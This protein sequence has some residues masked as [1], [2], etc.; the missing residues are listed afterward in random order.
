M[1]E[2]RTHKVKFFSITPLI[3]KIGS[4]TA[5][6]TGGVWAGGGLWGAKMRRYICTREDTWCGEI[7][8]KQEE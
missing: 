7:G 1:D 4:Y 2:P 6:Q 3:S 8:E 5:S